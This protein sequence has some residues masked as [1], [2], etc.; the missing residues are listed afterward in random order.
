M[1]D[2]G[3]THWCIV[4]SDPEEK[5]FGKVGK[6][7]TMQEAIRFAEELDTDRIAAIMTMEEPYREVTICELVS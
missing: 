3:S 2:F 7:Y 5:Y 1:N 4:I 6:F